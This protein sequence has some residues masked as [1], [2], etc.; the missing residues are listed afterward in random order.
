MTA[1]YYR[2]K[3]VLVT[4]ASG[5][6]GSAIAQKFASLGAT[7]ALHYLTKAPDAAD[8][9][10]AQGQLEM[11]REDLSAPDGARRLVDDV[12]ARCGHV[13]IIVNNAGAVFGYTHFTALAEDE[14]ARCT[15]L[16]LLAPFRIVA[17]L[18]DSLRARGGGRI[19][20]ITSGSIRYGRGNSAHYAM[21]K[22][23]LEGLTGVWSRDG[24]P[25]GIL[26]NAIRCGVIDSGFSERID[27]YDGERLRARTAMVPI[28]R[29][30][31]PE[32]VADTAAYLAG[33]SG[34]FI[35][36][37]VIYLSGGE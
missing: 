18:W 16:N 26:A 14:L 8:L 11:F 9:P 7:L 23:G 34:S 31:R 24:A 5:G 13:D 36:G 30:G 37:Q 25:V 29:A 28:G 17:G 22:A 32:E 15:E 27:G 6:I 35:S 10:G 3:V 1:D 33:P 19:I 4:G 21:A 20:S 2:G 12:L